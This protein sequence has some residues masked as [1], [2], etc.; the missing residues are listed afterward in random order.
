M[1][2]L[3]CNDECTF[4]TTRFDNFEISRE[5]GCHTILRYIGQKNVTYIRGTLETSTF[6][7]RSSSKYVEVLSTKTFHGYMDPSP[8]VYL[9]FQI[10]FLFSCVKLATSIHAFQYQNFSN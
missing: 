2:I 4:A 1:F 10:F 7:E 8:S 5:A 9:L 6:Q 3:L